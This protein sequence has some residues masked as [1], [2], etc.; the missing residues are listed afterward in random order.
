MKT[1]STKEFEEKYGKDYSGLIGDASAVIKEPS[2]KD[3]VVSRIRELREKRI[4]QF[5]DVLTNK[6]QGSIPERIVQGAGIA[7][8]PIGDIAGS[9]VGEIPG[10][11][12]ALKGVA[13]GVGFIAKTEPIR[14][15]GSYLES[16]ETIKEAKD[17]YK[18]DPN[19]KQTL[20]SAFNIL[21][22]MVTV[23]GLAEGA[24]ILTGA[25][26][27]AVST[28]ATPAGALVE[29]VSSKI[30]DVLP[31]TKNLINP[32]NTPTKAVK[33]V[34][35]G[36]TKDIEPGVRALAEIDINGT[37]KFSTLSKKIDQ[38]TKELL[39][40]VDQA[41]EKDTNL[42]KLS[43]L[44]LT[45]KSPSGVNVD[46]NPVEDAINHLEELY[47]STNDRVKLQTLNEL[48]DKAKN[49]GLTR[50]EV[51]NLSRQ[52]GTEF[53]E[54]AFGKTGEP[55][56]SVN[57]ISYE[58]TR[59]NLKDVAR[60]GPGGQEAGKIDAVISSLI[61]T[62]KLVKKNIEGVQKLSSRIAERGLLE[63]FGHYTT[64]YLDLLSGGTLRGLVGGLLP[65]GVGNKVLNLL[66]LEEKL[67]SNLKIIKEALKADGN[68]IEK[69]IKKL[70]NE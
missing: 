57:A 51:N 65:R 22:A 13:K 2:Y 29:N 4:D 1:I 30:K 56:T 52:Y 38:K 68:D 70:I 69:F 62:N 25:G 60:S 54:K 44:K 53:G 8:A 45:K 31:K 17:A 43:D 34:L 27:K 61:N 63:K 35:L 47:R 36:K 64:K 5:G 28:A 14:K 24:S 20:D 39:P 50:V 3:R 7:L 18:D 33:Q 23:K 48:K 6:N 15:L 19:F 21:N 11:E 40:K 66:D 59:S 16:F 67:G 10:V 58:N 41:L 12:T 32:P 26:K 55:R 46:M 49:T 37:T 9:V 42:Y